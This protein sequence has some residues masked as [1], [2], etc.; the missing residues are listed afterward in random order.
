[1]ESE[2]LQEI[3]E[4]DGVKEA[5]VVY[6]VYDLIVMVQAPTLD[7]LKR[8]ITRGIRGLDRVHATLTLLAA[9]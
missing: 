8:A 9:E 6:G 7:E 5:H 4:V 1:M 2:L 3:R